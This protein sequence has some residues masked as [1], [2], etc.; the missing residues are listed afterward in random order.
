[1]PLKYLGGI[2]SAVRWTGWVHGVLFILFCLALLFAMRAARWSWVKAGVVF[3]AA[4][5]PFGPFLIDRRLRD[6]DSAAA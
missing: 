4:L 6:E 1:M 5:L 2:E 3:V